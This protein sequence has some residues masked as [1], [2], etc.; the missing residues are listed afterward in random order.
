MPAVVRGGRRANV[1]SAP[2]RGNAPKGSSGRG[3]AAPRNVGGVPGKMAALG[4]LDL[5]P[6]AVVLSICAGVAVLALVLATGARADRIGQSFHQGVDEVTTGMGLSLRRVHITG[7]SAEAE[8]AIQRALDVRSGQPITSIDLAALQTS[9]QAVGWV[10][11]ARVVR[12]LPDTL[13]VEV[14]EHD[15]LAVWQTGGRV[16]V[17]DGEGRAI[18]GADPGRY[19]K[20]PL[21]VGV[22]ADKAARDILPLLRERPRLM[23]RID[24]LVRVDER[25]WDLRLRDGGLIQLPAVKQEAAL[26]QLDALDQRE[27]LL[28]LGFARID[29]RT[30]GQVAVRP[31]AGA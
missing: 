30:E 18:R 25:R 21:V 15:R 6:R 5:S 24:A 4:R 17:I 3:R 28:E 20:L 11:E 9:V 31:G 19:P 29:L 7:A 26:I 10:R 8:P 12:L 23:S 14:K 27:R 16:F 2:K 22:G 13:I 1:A